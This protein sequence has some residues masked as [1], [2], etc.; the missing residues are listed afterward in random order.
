MNIKPGKGS[1][2]FGEIIG[3]QPNEWVNEKTR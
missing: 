2:A 3:E 1:F